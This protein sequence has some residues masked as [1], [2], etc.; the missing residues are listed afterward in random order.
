MNKRANEDSQ[1]K[2]EPAARSST[3]SEQQHALKLQ[4]AQDALDRL[5]FKNSNEICTEFSTRVN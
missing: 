4:A 1:T 5:Y 3:T 2:Q